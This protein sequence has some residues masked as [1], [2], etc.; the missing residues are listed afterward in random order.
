MSILCLELSTELVSHFLLVVFVMI[1]NPIDYRLKLQSKTT[2]EVVFL[3]IF[4]QTKTQKIS[5]LEYFLRFFQ[6]IFFRYS[7]L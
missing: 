6:G 2:K 4:F 3:A 5:R 7:G 1:V